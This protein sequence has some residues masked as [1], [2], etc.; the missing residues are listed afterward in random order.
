MKNKKLSVDEIKVGDKVIFNDGR[1][2]LT[3]TIRKIDLK[4]REISVTWRRRETFL[5]FSDFVN[6]Y[7]TKK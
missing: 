3:L 2:K 5:M 1:E 6:G 7:I 4:K